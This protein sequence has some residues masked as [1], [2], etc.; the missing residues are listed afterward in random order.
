MSSANQS[1]ASADAD[2]SLY[3]DDADYYDLP[4]LN[5][6]TTSLIYQYSLNRAIHEP[7]YSLFAAAYG[8]LIFLTFVGNTFVIWAV[9]R[10]KEMWTARNIFILNLA[11]A[12]ICK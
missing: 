10:R 9:V 3:Y 8:V 4:P 1:S 6:K 5:E 12:D 2:D 7:W 11:V